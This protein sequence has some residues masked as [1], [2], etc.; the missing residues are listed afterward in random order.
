MK[1]ILNIKLYAILILIILI[2]SCK[3]KVANTSSNDSLLFCKK[4][5]SFLCSKKINGNKNIKNSFQFFIKENINFPKN[6]KVINNDSFPVLYKFPLY[7]ILELD[8]KNIINYFID[9]L[10][11]DVKINCFSQKIYAEN[12]EINYYMKIE[13]WHG[14][15]QN[16]VLELQELCKSYSQNNRF[17][18]SR[19]LPY[20]LNFGFGKNKVVFIEIY[21]NPKSSSNLV[22]SDTLLQ[23]LLH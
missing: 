5:D 12:K 13:M 21:Y 22:S 1:Y 8:K 16:N 20:F 2:N 4:V 17:H 15:Q 10:K 7:D 19:E 6:N 23:A 11:N 14:L 18:M 9:S 3:T